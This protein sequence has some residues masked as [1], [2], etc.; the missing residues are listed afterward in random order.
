MIPASLLAVLGLVL[1]HLQAGRLR[2]LEVIPRS[3]LLSLA[4][5]MSVAYVFLR[6]LPDLGT[7]QARVGPEVGDALMIPR[8]PIYMVSLAGLMV[9]Y[10]LQ[11]LTARSRKRQREVAGEDCPTPLVFWISMLSYST[12]NFAVGYLLFQ[13]E[14]TDRLRLSLFF[15]AMALWFLVNDYGLR[16][17]HRERYRRVG[18]WVLSAVIV[19]GWVAGLLAPLPDAMLSLVLAF[20]AGGIILNVLKEELPEERESRF[21][22]FAAGAA[23]YGALLLSI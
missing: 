4:G 7:S 9:F 5:G 3:R 22:A 21:W 18:R 13:R 23:A 1:I 19:V 8:H 2:F 14:G 11:R 15:L 16:Q 20:V 17:E 6:I 10:G 12:V